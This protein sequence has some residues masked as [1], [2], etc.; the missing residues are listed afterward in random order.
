M[1][2]IYDDIIDLPHHVSQSRPRMSSS[3]RAAQFAPFSA[4]TGYGATVREVGRT[5]HERIVLDDEKIEKINRKLQYISEHL[6]EK[7]IVKITYYVPDLKKS[8]GAYVSISGIV[9]KI[10][11]YEKCV[12]FF[13]GSNI[14]IND[15]F[16]L[17]IG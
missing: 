7:L 12:I 4:L 11:E 9:K 16:N 10:D 13:D 3:D 2:G 14:P 15:I 8:G 5:T 6:D 1:S 17:T